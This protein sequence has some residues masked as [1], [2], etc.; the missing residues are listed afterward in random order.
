MAWAI[1]K[2]E[3]LE[4]D[5]KVIDDLKIEHTF[6]PYILKR[7]GFDSLYNKQ[8]IRANERYLAA[9]NKLYRLFDIPDKFLDNRPTKVVFPNTFKQY[10][11]VYADRDN[12]ALVYDIGNKPERVMEQI[13]THDG[14]CWNFAIET[15]HKYSVD[16]VVRFVSFETDILC[17][18][19]IVKAKY[20]IE[21]V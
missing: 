11:S 15:T 21:K 18:I 1:Y 2:Q 19:A 13:S 20:T 9:I 10:S 6:L 12:C 5:W 14:N 16:G 3:Y 8:Q 17:W 7:M 4:I